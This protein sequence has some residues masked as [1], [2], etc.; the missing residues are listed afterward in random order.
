MS[1]QWWETDHVDFHDEALIPRPEFYIVCQGCGE[2]FATF[3]LETL[4]DKCPEC[5]H[6]EEES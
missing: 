5:G 4:P 3:S 1:R 2:V 6:P